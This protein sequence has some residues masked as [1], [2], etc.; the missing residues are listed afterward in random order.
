M[1]PLTPREHG[2]DRLPLLD[3]AAVRELVLTVTGDDLLHE[4]LG[5]VHDLGR[6][7][8]QHVQLGVGIGPPRLRLGRLQEAGL[9][10]RLD[11]EGRL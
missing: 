9:D 11:G 4:Q 1:L 5:R 6:A 7:L 2:A 10:R 8:E 3:E